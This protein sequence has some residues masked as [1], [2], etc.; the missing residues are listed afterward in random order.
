MNLKTVIKSK[1]RNAST[2]R[3]DP[4]Y[5]WIPSQKILNGTKR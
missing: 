2:N 4:F 5:V 1:N 3:S